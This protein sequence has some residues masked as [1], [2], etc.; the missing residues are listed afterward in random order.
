MTTDR[1]QSGRAQGDPQDIRLVTIPDADYPTYRRTVIFESC[2]WDPQ[3]GDVNTISNHIIIL[4]RNTAEQ[5]CRWT[6]YLAAETM[7]LEEELRRKPALL[8]PLGLPRRLEAIFRKGV[9]PPANPALR[10]M[11]FD[12]HPTTDGWAI[13]EVNSDVPGG[14]G[15]ASCMS[16]LA[17]PFAP[18]TLPFGNVAGL[19]ATRT[20]HAVPEGSRIAL[21][22]AT[23]YADDRQVMEYIGRN[24][25]AAG[26]QPIPV[27]PDH[28]AWSDSGAAC[29]AAGYEGPLA[30]IV[31]F[32]PCEWLP[33][34]PRSARWQEYFTNATVPA[35]NPGSALLT[36]SKRLPLLW[37]RSGCQTPTWRQLLPETV[38][39]A[40]LS[41]KRNP[42]WILKPAFGRV[43]ESITVPEATTAAER[44]KAR[45]HATLF[46]RQWV[47]QRRFHS[48]PILSP[49]GPLHLCIGSFAL[50][51]KACGFYGRISTLPRIDGRAQDVAILV[52]TPPVPPQGES[53]P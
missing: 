52:E 15:E 21:V 36:Q 26:L 19:L 33:A 4:S 38:E 32:Y 47:A 34:L 8:A 18:G 13:S 10:I 29:I 1:T 20:A 40:R 11:R 7:E 41:L 39:S 53:H 35:C 51:G 6:E 31:R 24:L 45:A 23:S 37:D 30:A 44:R 16:R 28:V 5:L 14:F 22:H 17:V 46:P 49:S 50:G 48:R 12:F 42:D 43:G 27:A 3:V 2:K 25:S 9:P